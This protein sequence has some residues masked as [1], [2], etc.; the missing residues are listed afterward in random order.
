MFQIFPGLI[1]GGRAALDA[2][3]APPWTPASLATPPVLWLEAGASNLFQSNAGSGARP[4]TDGDYV[5]YW[6]DKSANAFNLS[7]LADDTAR[8][9]WYANSGKP[10]VNFDGTS[11]FLRRL[12]NLGLYSSA[13]GYAIFVAVRGVSGQSNK[14][15]IAQ[16]NGTETGTIFAPMYEAASNSLG[17]LYRDS[18]STTVFQQTLLSPNAF[19]GSDRVVAITD[20]GTGASVIGYTD[21]TA[22]TQRT[23]TRAS[24]TIDRF[25][26]GCLFRATPA[27][28]FAA[29]IY[30][31]LA[32]PYVPDSTTRGHI[33][34]YL[35]SLM[36]K[37]L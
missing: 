10:Y 1:A 21:G 14:Y 36:G 37:T 2:A 7:S 12:T 18:A 30:G 8:G 19:D 6:A 16:G 20:D 31:L 4:A 32:L 3:A 9:Q 27:S 25:A 34:T 17:A 13:S 24:L 5:G 22:G 26:L 33:N 11:Q 28:Y 23:Y 35:G 15:L 29:R